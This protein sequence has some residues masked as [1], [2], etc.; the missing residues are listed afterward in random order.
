M[1]LDQLNYKPHQLN[2]DISTKIKVQ[3]SAGKYC[4]NLTSNDYLKNYKMKTS[5]FHGLPKIH[6]SKEIPENIKGCT[7]VYTELPTPSDLKLQTNCSC[8]RPVLQYTNTQQSTGHTIKPLCQKVTSFI[9]DDM[10]FLNY[11][12]ETVQPETILVSFDVTSRYTN[13]LHDMGIEAV[14]FWL[15]KISR[16]NY[17]EV[18]K[19]VYS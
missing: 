19:P 7:D 17:R 1:V 4:N 11:I 18:Y 16:R 3:N 2:Q 14:N 9:R 12:P 10:D 13:I 8:S 5:N 6:K 15:E